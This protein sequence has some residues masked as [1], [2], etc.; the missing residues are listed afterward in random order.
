[1]NPT[2]SLRPVQATDIPT[3]FAHQWEVE[4]LAMSGHP[5]REREAF[6]AHWVRILA[7]DTTRNECVICDGRVAG[8]VCR[9]TMAGVPSV[10]YWLGKEWW[11]KGIATRALQLLLESEE[12]R[13]LFAGV[14]PQ[15][16]ASRRVL[17]KCGFVFAGKEERED[18]KLDA[19]MRL[20]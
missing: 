12:T 7:D 14:A 20:D 13:P 16:G 6:F 8:Y 1:M 10:A 19:V 15:N 5:P 9:F 18:G 4:A 11:G 2:V 3:F 17:E